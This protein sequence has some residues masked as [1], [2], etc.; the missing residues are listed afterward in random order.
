M[1]MEGVRS[2]DVSIHN[3]EPA[4]ADRKDFRGVLSFR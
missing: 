1:V 2:N 3:R 4:D